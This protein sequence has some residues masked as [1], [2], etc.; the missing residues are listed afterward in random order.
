MFNIGNHSIGG[1]KLHFVTDDKAMI[2][3]AIASNAKYTVHTFDE[4]MAYLK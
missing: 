2:R 3:T 4:Y 1:D